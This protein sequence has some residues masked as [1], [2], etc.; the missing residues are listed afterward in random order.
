MQVWEDVIEC[1]NRL[2]AFNGVVDKNGDLATVSRRWAERWM[3]RHKEW[4]QTLKS[5]PLSYLRRNAHNRQDII[6][7]FA[8]FKRCKEKW[9]I[10]DS[11]V[12]NFD[13]TGC[14]IGISARSRVVV[15]QA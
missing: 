10:L 14:Q 5:K 3:G 9:G 2:L 4:L 1:S 7:H 13:E 11:D 8:D 12:Y 6:D 15:P